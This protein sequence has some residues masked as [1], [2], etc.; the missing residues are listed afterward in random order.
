MKV[1]GEVRAKR[2][3]LVLIKCKAC[4]SWFESISLLSGQAFIPEG[5]RVTVFW[6]TSNRA[7][8]FLQT[9]ILQSHNSCAREP[10]PRSS[11]FTMQHR[12]SLHSSFGFS[13]FVPKLDG[14]LSPPYLH[15]TQLN[16]WWFCFWKWHFW[17]PYVQTQSDLKARSGVRTLTIGL[18]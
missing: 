11:F 7:S 8:A 16:H 13:A 14:E 4:W 2:G 1:F 5:S 15:L 17:V 10:G 18:G 12:Q 3:T 6:R 9:S